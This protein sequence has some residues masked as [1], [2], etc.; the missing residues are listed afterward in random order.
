MVRLQ[1][2][3][4][5]NLGNEVCIVTYTKGERIKIVDSLG[6][7]YLNFKSAAHHMAY[8]KRL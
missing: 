3:E 5:S 7:V 8:K 4:D 1:N 6:V 2:P